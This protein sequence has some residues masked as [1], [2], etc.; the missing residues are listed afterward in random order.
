MRGWYDSFMNPLIVATLDNALRA[1]H[2]PL[3]KHL[4]RCI[5]CKNANT[6]FT[7]AIEGSVF[8][9]VVYMTHRLNGDSYRLLVVVLHKSVITSAI[10]GGILVFRNA[11]LITEWP[12]ISF[13]GTIGVALICSMVKSR[14]LVGVAQGSLPEILPSW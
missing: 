4:F 7:S 14:C 13:L 3:Y 10:S 12:T 1:A 11:C 5:P 9:D 8:L 6:V 2:K